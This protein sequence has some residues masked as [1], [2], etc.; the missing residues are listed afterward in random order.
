MA[1]KTWPQLAVGRDAEHPL[2]RRVIS[3]FGLVLGGSAGMIVGGL[4]AALLAAL[5]FPFVPHLIGL[6]VLS[7]TLFSVA[8]GAIVGRRVLQRETFE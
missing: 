1:S 4:G 6:V 7:V 3:C 8:F 2:A 5:L